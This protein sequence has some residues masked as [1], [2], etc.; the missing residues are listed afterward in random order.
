[1]N[2]IF[3]AIGAALLPAIVLLIYIYAKD[4]YQHEPVGQMLKG[5][6]FGVLSCF[7]AVSIATVL[8]YYGLYRDDFGTIEGAFKTAFFGAAIPEE[9]AKLF[10][11][12][13]LLRKNKHFD[14]YFDGIVYA[15]T[16]GMGFAGLENVLY[17]IDAEEWQSVAIMRAILSVP[18]H[19][20]FAVLMGFFYSNVHFRNGGFFSGMM[21]IVAP[22]V[23]HG[24][25]DAILMSGSIVENGATQAII[26]ML[27]FAFFIWA[28]KRAKRA[29]ERHLRNDAMYGAG[30]E[31]EQMPGDGIKF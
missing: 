9:C 15:V 23:L 27:F 1:M 25:F 2:N 11:L 13:L 19:Y 31:D 29:I 24:L 20:M 26:V 4:K 22:V 18:G 10:F 8:Q 30:F 28:Q 5:V 16:V 21:V 17:V 3:M 12:W 7:L 14:E 6:V